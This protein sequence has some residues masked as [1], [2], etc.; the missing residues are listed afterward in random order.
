LLQK[1]ADV[2]VKAYN[3][4]TALLSAKRAN[5]ADIVQ[6]LEKAGAKQ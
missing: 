2:N 1:G 4:Q 6:M 3:G 5:R